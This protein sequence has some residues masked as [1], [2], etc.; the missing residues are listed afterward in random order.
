MATEKELISSIPDPAQP[1]DDQRSNE[2]QSSSSGGSSTSPTLTLK[3][4]LLDALKLNHECRGN[5]LLFNRTHT[6]KHW[7]K[8]NYL[9]ARET[10]CVCGWVEVSSVFGDCSE[11]KIATTTRKIRN[12]VHTHIKWWLQTTMPMMLM[13]MTMSSRARATF[14]FTFRFVLHLDQ[15][16][17]L[18]SH[19]SDARSFQWLFSRFAV[20]PAQCVYVFISCC[21]TSHSWIHVHREGCARPRYFSSITITTTTADRPAS[22]I[23]F[24]SPGTLL[25][26]AF[27]SHSLW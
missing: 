5:G 17:L 6:E 20:H 26:P 8:F 12:D 14:A 11:W 4:I 2:A 25:C 16:F 19:A 10:V 27:V 21:D 15:I 7:I 23:T 9:N 3:S 13:L 18:F 24:F 22:I 1:A